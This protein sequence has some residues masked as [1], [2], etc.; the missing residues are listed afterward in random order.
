M[1]RVPRGWARWALDPPSRALPLCSPRPTAKRDF[2]SQIS[3]LDG[4]PVRFQPPEPSSSSHFH[5]VRRSCVVVRPRIV[6][7]V[8][9]VSCCPTWWKAMPSRS[10]NVLRGLRRRCMRVVRHMRECRHGNTRRTTVK[11]RG[12]QRDAR[13]GKELAEG[14]SARTIDKHGPR[15]P[16]NDHVP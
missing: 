6:G 3:P 5:D 11:I 9:A 16:L 13:V 1:A 7:R 14:M 8:H 12:F 4:M 10:I 2:S 15:A